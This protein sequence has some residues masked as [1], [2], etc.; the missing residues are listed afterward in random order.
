MCIRDSKHNL[1]MRTVTEAE[2]NRLVSKRHLMLKNGTCHSVAFNRKMKQQTRR[3]IAKRK[4]AELRAKA[5]KD[6]SQ[7]AQK[8]IVAG[9]VGMLTAYSD[10]DT[11]DSEDR[12]AN[13]LR[14]N[15]PVKDHLLQVTPQV[16]EKLSRRHS[17]PTN[18]IVKAQPLS[19][20]V[21]LTQTKPRLPLRRLMVSLSTL[22]PLITTVMQMKRKKRKSRRAP[23]L[24]LIHI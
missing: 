4:R 16:M 18:Q 15:P 24:S 10:D 1:L 9:A 11:D 7:D 19:Q 22:P 2:Y 23:A 14:A 20:R 3:S 13:Q 5:V 21:K 6:Q 12:N 17:L 8:A